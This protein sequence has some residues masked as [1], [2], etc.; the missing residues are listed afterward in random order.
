[1]ELLTTLDAAENVAPPSIE[2]FHRYQR[3]AWVSSITRVLS[4]WLLIVFALR[5][6][7]FTSGSNNA[8]RNAGVEG[9]G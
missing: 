2:A 5:V 3:L 9:C 6:V 4:I 1:M 8:D 7:K